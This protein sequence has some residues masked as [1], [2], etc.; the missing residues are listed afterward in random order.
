MKLYQL[1]RA[2]PFLTRTQLFELVEGQIT[3]R[4]GVPQPTVVI[5]SDNDGGG[6][7]LW[8]FDPDR[9]VVGLLDCRFQ[10]Q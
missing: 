6:L 1:I 5:F 10:F 9:L 2:C 7:R 8:I 4:H 3:L